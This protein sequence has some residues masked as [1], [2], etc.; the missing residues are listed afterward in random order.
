[1]S[2][3]RAVL[4]ANVLIHAPL[5][6]TLLRAVDGGLCRGSGQQPDERPGAAGHEQ[7]LHGHDAR[8]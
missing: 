4:D 2:V 3:V 1:M 5:R 6:D 8:A 7:E